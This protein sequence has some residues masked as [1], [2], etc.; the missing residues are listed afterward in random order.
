MI[1][2]LKD[3]LAHPDVGHVAI[4]DRITAQP[5]LSPLKLSALNGHEF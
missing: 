1:F 5:E 3:Y 2:R 4:A